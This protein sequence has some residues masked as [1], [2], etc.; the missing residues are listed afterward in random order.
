MRHADYDQIAAVFDGNADRLDIPADAVLGRLLKHNPQAHILDVGCGTGNY[1]AIQQAVFG[2]GRWVGF[3]PSLEMLAVAQGKTTA[4]LSQAVAENM[5]HPA[6]S[7]D[8]V[9]ANFTFHHFKDKTAVLN[10][11]IRILKPDGLLRIYNLCPE[12]MPNWWVYQLF[13]T[14]VAIDEQRFWSIARLI[15]GLESRGLT[16]DVEIEVRG[17]KRPLIELH[18]Q[19]LARDTSQIAILNADEYA[20]GLE[21]VEKQLITNPDAMIEYEI[22]FLHCLARGKETINRSACH[23]ADGIGLL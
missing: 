1:T 12:K 17:I 10:E 2:T 9:A 5:P 6:R 16:V 20:A 4:V 7:F 3:D 8:Y 13:P 11:L 23:G 18:T 21:R 22:A 15:D 19:I 14:T